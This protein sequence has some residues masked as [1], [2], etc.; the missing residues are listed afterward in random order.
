MA[1]IAG[2][3]G[4]VT[5]GFRA[6]GEHGRPRDEPRTAGT[7]RFGAHSQLA[8]GFLEF[9]KQ[10]TGGSQQQTELRGRPCSPNQ[11]SSHPPALGPAYSVRKPDDASTRPVISVLSLT[12]HPR[13]CPT[14]LGPGFRC[15][16]KQAGQD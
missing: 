10:P 11:V 7:R 14:H 16:A 6:L 8:G 3:L 5:G 15:P 12:P 2:K 13:L 1:V 4:Q 9:W